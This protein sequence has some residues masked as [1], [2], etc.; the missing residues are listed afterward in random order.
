MPKLDT[1]IDNL[2]RKSNKVMGTVPSA[3][4]TDTQYPSAKTLYNTYATL[5]DMMHP[6]NSILTTATN[7]NPA[8]TLGGTWE[9]VDKGFKNAYI[10][11]DSSYWTGTNA[12]ISTY[13]NI[14]LADHTISLRLAL[15][16]T[17]A[18]TDNTTTLGR[19]AIESCG[20]D[21]LSHAIFC[22]AAVSDEGNCTVNY[23]IE[24]TGEVKIYDVLNADGTHSM[25]SNSTLYIHLVQPINHL[26]MHDDFCDKFYW[27]RTA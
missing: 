7:T 13:S 17:A 22:E 10:T 3:S 15:T 4:W 14:M 8:A 26:S 9:L 12:N 19:L 18:M 5:L 11:L 24:Q 1:T 2:E 6:V 25:A 21:K 16:T 27:K 20:I 23:R